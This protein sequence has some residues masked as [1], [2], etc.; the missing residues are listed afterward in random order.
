MATYEALTQASLAKGDPV[1]LFLEALAAAFVQMRSII[2]AAGKN[3]LASLAVGHA[4]DHIG[5]L[6]DTPRLKETKAKTTIR[7]FVNLSAT[8]GRIDAGTRVTPDS[9]LMFSVVETIEIPKGA[10]YVDVAAECQMPGEVGN[11][12]LPGQIS[13]IVDPHIYSHIL[14][15]ENVTESSG[16]SDVEDDEAY[17]DRFIKSWGKFSAAGPEMSYIYY[18]KTACQDIVD[19][20]VYRTSPID[21]LG[22]AAL[23]SVAA[24]ISYLW[25]SGAG[26]EEKKRLLKIALGA[27]V[28]NVRPL[29]KGGGVPSAEV[30]SDVDSI[31][32]AESVRPLTDDVNV[33]A[34]EAVNY[35]IEATYF[36]KGADI[37]SAGAIRIAVAKAVE[38]FKLWQKE[39]LG[40]DINP[41][42]LIHR[43]QAAGAKRVTLA[44]PSHAALKRWQFAS[45]QT[46]T[47]VDGGF[48]D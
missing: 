14:S 44:A 3:N 34:P 17:R 15:A 31:L 24:A 7:F 9:K 28:V 21:D 37:S 32:S 18:V 2:D 4:Q 25:P 40:R 41:T 23:D 22:E 8:A 48:E 35:N 20:A 13:R 16:G 1:R 46:T 27:A 47:I 38:D 6:T 26:Q 45:D 12:F 42:E 10:D 5:A 36:L 30:L 39:K 19:V 43:M 29:M 11:G 33:A